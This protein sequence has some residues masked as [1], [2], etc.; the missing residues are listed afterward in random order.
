V[1]FMPQGFS[2]ISTSLQQVHPDLEESALVSG[3]SRVRAATEVT[4]PLI[5]SSIISAM[6]LLLILSMRELSAAIFLFTSD[7]RVLSVVIFDFW[8][9]GLFGRA[10]AASLL[11]SALLGVVAIFARRYL[12][13]KTGE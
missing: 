5:R 4:M 11:Y 3:A 9:S 12:G 2:S 7:T 13:A 8:D 10:A 6:L 1:R